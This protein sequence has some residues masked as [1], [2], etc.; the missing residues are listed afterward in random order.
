MNSRDT[1][2]TE[3]NVL[4]DFNPV[5]PKNYRD[6]KVVMLGNL[7]PLVQLSVIEQMTEKPGLVILDSGLTTGHPFL[8]PA[9]GDAQSFL[10][11]KA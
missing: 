7:H 11:G 1:L 10:P 3:L 2:A 5:V 9:V 8:A 4:A 6:S